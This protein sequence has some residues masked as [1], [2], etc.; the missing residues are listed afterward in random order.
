MYNDTTVNIDGNVVRS[1]Y[2]YN[3][4]GLIVVG[5]TDGTALHIK[6]HVEVVSEHGEV[7]KSLNTGDIIENNKK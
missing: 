1:F 6:G 4:D 3:H 2:H 5:F 7:L